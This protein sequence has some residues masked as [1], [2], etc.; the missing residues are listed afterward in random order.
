MGIRIKLSS[1]ELASCRGDRVCVRLCVTR[2][3]REDLLLL[4]LSPALCLH[5]CYTN[6]KQTRKKKRVRDG[7]FSSYDLDFYLSNHIDSSKMA[8][9]T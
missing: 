7:E 4:S 3:E 2:V 8:C 6:V 5:F 9:R 1:D